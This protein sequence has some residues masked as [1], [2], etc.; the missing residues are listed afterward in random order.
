MMTVF[1]YLCFANYINFLLNWNQ[2]SVVN[3]IAS[4]S[5]IKCFYTVL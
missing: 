1:Y 2:E 4:F 3:I 5:L